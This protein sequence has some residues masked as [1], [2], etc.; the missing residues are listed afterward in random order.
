MGS[1]MNLYMQ[2]MHYSANKSPG[3]TG[4]V[5]TASLRAWLLLLRRRA[6]SLCLLACD[7]WGIWTHWGTAT[8]IKIKIDIYIYIYY[9][10][11]DDSSG[12]NL[13]DK[14]SLPISSWIRGGKANGCHSLQQSLVWNQPSRRHWIRFAATIAEDDRFTPKNPLQSP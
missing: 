10:T 6:E 2:Y 11:S 14:L 3:T 13:L 8:P 4:G 12:L 1:S 7:W 9:C 5:G